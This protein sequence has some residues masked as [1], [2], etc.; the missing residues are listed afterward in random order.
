MA[1]FE[2]DPEWFVPP[3][4]LITDAG[5]D[6]LPW[7]FITPAIPIARMHEQYVITEV[8]PAPLA[9]QVAHVWQEVVDLLDDLGFHVL[10]AQPWIEGVAL[11]ELRD[12]GESFAPIHMVPKDLGNDSF[13]RCMR[14]NEGVGFRG[15]AG[16]REGCL[17][18]LGV[19]LDFRN[20]ND[21]WAAVNIFGEFHHWVS[22]DLYLVRSIVCAS[23]PDDILV[24]CSVT[25]FDY[26]AWG[27]ERVSWS[28]RLFILG[29][30]FAEQMPNDEDRM[31]LNG[32]PH[33]LPGQLEQDNLV[34]ALLPYLALGWNIVP[35]PP[36]PPMPEPPDQESMVID[37][38]TSSDSVQEIVVVDPQ[39]DDAEAAAEDAAIADHDDE[40]V[41]DVVAA[42]HDPPNGDNA[43]EEEAADEEAPA[44]FNPLVIVPLSAAPSAA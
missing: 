14:H 19:P 24:P 3:S 31:P 32:N 20:T 44:E 39:L 13:V 17:L 26:A 29:A 41:H 11:L 5:H 6:R 16:F 9:D 15:A 30:G 34:F 23:F 37:Q 18:F 4:N 28:A 40:A 8:M 7:T 10:S 38:P 12:A 21:L 33:P 35:P 25:F 2:L 27:G 36:P 22:D 42:A 1:N 43:R